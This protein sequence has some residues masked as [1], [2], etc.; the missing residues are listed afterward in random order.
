MTDVVDKGMVLVIDD[1][2]FQLDVLGQQL[3][4]LGWSRVLFA[5][6]GE[7]ALR[8]YDQHQADIRLILSDLSM[9]DMD[10][11]VLMRHFAQRQLN[12]AIILISGVS[13]E[14]LNSAAGLASAH[15]LHLLGVLSKPNT[16]QS[17][18]ALLRR[19]D[20]PATARQRDH[21]AALS[22]ERLRRA[23]ERNEFVPWYQPKV[24]A[25][26]GR[27]QAVEALARWPGSLPGTGMVG[28]GHFI[29]AI[30]S[31][32]LSDALFY[33]MARQ[34]IA[35]VTVWRAQGF[36]IKAAINLS[37]DTALN[38]DMPETLHQLVLGSGLQARDF[39]I[40]VTES[41]LMVQRSLAME[42][43]TR[44]SLMGFTLS[45]DD[46]GTG[47]SSL[48]QLVDLPFRELKIDGSFVQR[49]MLEE[50]ARTILRI[51]ATL[52][53]SLKM[54]VTAEG[55]ETA[56]QLQYV[57]ECGCDTV[58]G[59]YFARPMSFKACTEWLQSEA[60]NG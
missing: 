3:Q 15:N 48:V 38:L 14:I 12:A 42:S 11:L 41:R 2:N 46:F 16:L 37:M 18:E 54:D 20:A 44:L 59:F 24:H 26:S 35:D 31:A 7:A 13:E 53:S 55:V 43:L 39:I 60:R 10:G 29:P 30:E 40:E 50:K 17:L 56:E 51:A 28:P 36:A 45:I 33:A 9:P 4:N 8:L 21:A 5:P 49:S 25:G 6:S 52:G 58:Q 23:L 27:A 22:L 32:G 1:D 47:Y 19:L 34:V 57:Q